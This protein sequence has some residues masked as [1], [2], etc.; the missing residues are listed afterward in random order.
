M[1]NLLLN[2]LNFTLAFLKGFRGNLHKI[3]ARIENILLVQLLRDRHCGWCRDVPG[4]KIMT[5][6]IEN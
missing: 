4:H 1:E 3:L 2:N 5:C 6:G